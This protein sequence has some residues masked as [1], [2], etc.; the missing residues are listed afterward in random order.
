MS[1]TSTD[2]RPLVT[3]SG[4][5][6]ALTGDQHSWTGPQIAALAQ[7]GLRGADDSDLQVFFHVVRKTGLDPFARQIY[8]IYRNDPT[9]DTGRKATIQT[10]IDGFRLVAQR[11]ARRDHVQYGYED[12]QYRTHAG[13]WVESWDEPDLNPVSVKVTV[14][15]GRMRFPAIAH[16]R[17]YVQT[18]GGKP[19]R[20]WSQ[21]PAGQ[22]AKCAE[23]LALRKA[24]PVD[25]SGVYE[26]TELAASAVDLTD[27]ATPN[28]DV[29]P[30]GEAVAALVERAVAVAG[31]SA[32]LATVWADGRA[33]GLLDEPI[34]YE[35]TEGKLGNLLLHLRSAPKRGSET[36]VDVVDADVVD[37]ARPP[38][39][40]V[41]L[42][43]TKGG[44]LP[45]GCDPDE[46]WTDGHRPGC[47]YAI[48][49]Q[50]PPS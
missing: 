44:A 32:A 13:E 11:A 12:A 33:A 4:G 23:A 50:E 5:D 6:L 31:D 25:L 22:L 42:P 37:D 16:W 15:R 26:P 18:K 39:E 2:D 24:F 46:V 47:Q 20:M 27:P 19:T 17:E 43:P 48:P 7:L 35:G 41:P 10:A 8:M 3:M 29:L 9:S 21:M 1:T 36:K 14:L 30:V 34:T 28:P 38:V 49:V 40:D 45:C